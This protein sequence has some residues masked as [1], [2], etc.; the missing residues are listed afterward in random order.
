MRWLARGLGGLLLVALLA[1]LVLGV[2]VYLALPAKNGLLRVSGPT[3]ALTIERD[4]HGIPTIR[5][6]S[7]ADAW[8]GLGFAHAQDR[9]WQL[10]THRRIAAGRLAEAFGPAAVESD[11]FLRTLGARHRAEAQWAQASPAVREML[12]AYAAGINAFLAEHLRARPPEFW[13]LGVRPEA[14]SPVDSLA[15]STMMAWDLGGNW[16]SELLRMRLALTLPVERI[17]QLLP[18]YPGDRPLVTQDYATLYRHLGIGTEAAPL[19]ASAP[20]GF[21]LADWVTGGGEGAGSNNWVVAGKRSVSSQ[22]LLANDPH[23]K[24]TAPAL[25]YL[26]RLEAPGLKVAGATMPGL[27][28]VVLGQNEHIAW[29]FTNTAPDVQDLYLERIDQRD[30]DRYETPAGWEAFETRRETL[31]VRGAADVAITVRQTRHGPVLSDADMP[32]TEGLTGV[33]AG[34]GAPRYAIALRWTA[35]DNDA[36]ARTLEAGLGF[37]R[38]R[39]VDEFIQAAAGYVAP[40]QNMVVADAGRIAMVAAGRVPL[41]GPGHDLQGLAPALGWD[42]R[43]DWL[44]YLPADAAPSELDPARGWIATANHRIHGPQYPH[45]IGSEWALPYRQQRIERMLASRPLHDV[46]SM[47]AMQADVLSLATLRLLPWLRRARAD[48]PLAEAAQESLR[49]FDGTMASELAAPLIFWSWVRHLTVGVLADDLGDVLLQRQLAH[50]SFRDAI[51]GVLERDDTYW[52]DDQRTPAPESCAEQVDAAFARALEELASQY[53]SDLAAWRWGDAHQARAEHRPF[54]K[55]PAL[56]HWFELRTPVGGDTYTVNVGRV[57]L[58][59]DPATGELYLD[60][61][62]P[63]LRAIYDIAAPQRSRVMQS[64]GQ[65]GLVFSR[66]YRDFVEPWREV[67]YLPLWPRG[68]ARAVLELRPR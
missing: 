56:A 1:V 17:Q 13:L 51:E 2:Y 30:P 57:G 55:R 23:L 40:M 54:S 44:G 7:A 27:P 10:E 37:N 9:L 26:A 63:G 15:W 35:L 49:A 45:Y 39:S 41:R 20:A 12:E 34:G 52:C 48:H 8:F 43:Y 3:A 29:G 46:D 4:A 22:P 47:A 38:A 61:H 62:G 25:W 42:E 68:P 6:A 64:S 33:P 19:R 67:E 65:S 36:P 59:P 66:R 31:R 24:L 32:A 21:P 11:R 5:A 18:P 16:G 50:R 28:L 58:R 14:W 53:G 60:E